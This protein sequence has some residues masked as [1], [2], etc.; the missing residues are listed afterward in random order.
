L[1]LCPAFLF[2]AAGCTDLLS[3][4]DPLHIIILNEAAPAAPLCSS[5]VPTQLVVALPDP[6]A[7]LDGERIALLLGEREVRYVSGYRWDAPAPFLAQRALVEALNGSGCFTG[8]G[9]GSDGLNTPYRLSAQIRRM[10]F[11][12]DA[13]QPPHAAQVELSLILLNGING[14]IMGRHVSSVERQG[15]YADPYALGVGMEQALRQAALDAAAWCWS[16]L[17]GSS[18]H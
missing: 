3:K 14:K 4:P 15:D 9:V 16:V 17:K 1:F 10:H 7:G 13:S 11:K 12:Q 2:L 5:P 18:Y 6:H 8:V